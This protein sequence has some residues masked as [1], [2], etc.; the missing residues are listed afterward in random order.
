[1]NHYSI[2]SFRIPEENFEKRMNLKL[3][4]VLDVRTYDVALELPLSRAI[5]PEPDEAGTRLTT[6]LE[7]FGT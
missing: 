5:T 4:F 7:F 6:K 1:M 3:A 2:I